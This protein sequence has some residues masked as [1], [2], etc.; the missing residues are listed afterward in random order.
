MVRHIRNIIKF[1]NI[2]IVQFILYSYLLYVEFDIF[3]FSILY[4]YFLYVE[5]DI[6]PFN[7]EMKGDQ[8]L[9]LE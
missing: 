7:N 1:L 4:S 6:F 8:R 3:P 5:F 9:L 2:I